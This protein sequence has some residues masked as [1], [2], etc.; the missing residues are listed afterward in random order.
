MGDGGV[1]AL[2]AMINI[3]FRAILP[4]RQIITP[5]IIDAIFFFPFV[6]RTS[7]RI[8]ARL[9]KKRFHDSLAILLNEETNLLKE[10][11]ESSHKSGNF[12]SGKRIIAIYRISLQ[13]DVTKCVEEELIDTDKHAKIVYK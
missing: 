2:P 3:N 5:T 9:Q 6:R 8:V 13:Q 10:S 12:I 1:I 4:S 11:I 7:N